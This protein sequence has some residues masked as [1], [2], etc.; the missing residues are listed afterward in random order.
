MPN[1]E[2]SPKLGAKNQNEDQEEDPANP[3]TEET[4]EDIGDVP[5]EETEDEKRRRIWKEALEKEDAMRRKEIDHLKALRTALYQ[6]QQEF[7]KH[8]Q[9]VIDNS[10]LEGALKYAQEMDDVKEG[11]VGANFSKKVNDTLKSKSQNTPD[12]ESKDEPRIKKQPQ[13][14]TSDSEGETDDENDQKDSRYSNLGLHEIRSA[15]NGAARTYGRFKAKYPAFIPHFSQPYSME[16]GADVSELKT[17]LTKY[18]N[19]MKEAARCAASLHADET[20]VAKLEPLKPE[21]LMYCQTIAN[22]LQ[23]YNDVKF[24]NALPSSLNQNRDKNSQP[25]PMKTLKPKD[26]SAKATP[27]EFAIW[28][29]NFEVYF[30]TSNA[31]RCTPRIQQA[32]LNTCI[33]TDLVSEI[34]SRVSPDWP[35]FGTSDSIPGH[36]QI[37]DQYFRNKYPMHI[38]RAEFFSYKAPD[39]ST[40]SS[41]FITM[42]Q[43]IKNADLLRTPVH[44]ILTSFLAT[45]CPD[46][47]LRLELL[48]SDYLSLNTIVE[49]AQSYEQAKCVVEK[50]KDEE[51]FIANNNN[52]RQTQYQANKRVN[53]FNNTTPGQRFQQNRPTF[54]PQTGRG[55]NQ[56]QF[57]CMGCN[58]TAHIRSQCPHAEKTC[59]FCKIKGHLEHVCRKKQAEERQKKPETTNNVQCESTSSSEDDVMLAHESDFPLY[60]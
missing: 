56:Q 21:H 40:S 12:D 60:L 10:F 54:S 11:M 36:I 25:T 24:K 5:K 19:N 16:I 22:Y 39:A 37:L 43:K 44:D 31:D 29:E 45:N 2:H 3:G 32:F 14:P 35:V 50:P 20:L 53:Y 8:K 47:V 17:K 27:Q 58:S 33:D 59:N 15:Y 1:V 52:R 42:L 13:P 4:P 57:R 49:K 34:S 28:R 30:S 48:R 23:T 7:D 46:S 9:Q 26:L 38:R 41:Y 18:W 51:V 55:E 6:E